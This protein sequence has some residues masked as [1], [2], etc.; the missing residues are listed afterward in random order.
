[1]KY[2]ISYSCGHQEDVRLYGSRKDRESR[3]DWLANGICSKCYKAEQE[4][5]RQAESAAAAVANSEMGLPKLVGSDK[6]IAWAESIRKEILSD[7]PRLNEVVGKN[8]D[9]PGAKEYCELR[10]EL[11]GQTSAGWWIDHR[12]ESL[13]QMLRRRMS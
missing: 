7:M 12:N 3:A 10:A 1:M 11:L 2:E 6:Q 4:A 9:K 13:I 8:L 5:K